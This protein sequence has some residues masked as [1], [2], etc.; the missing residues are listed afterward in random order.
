MNKALFLDR[1]GVVNIDKGYIYKKE[2]FVFIE[3]VFELCKHFQV[4]NFLIFIITNQSGVA[5][6][7]YTE[8]ELIKL[9]EWLKEEFKNNGITLSKIYYSTS[10]DDND[11]FRKP[12]PGMLLEAKKEFDIDLE[13]SILIG[14]K[15]SDAQCGINAGVGKIFLY[16]NSTYKG[17]AKI[18]NIK[19]LYEA[20]LID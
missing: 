5:R 7:Y 17:N 2:D 3:G 16:N 8:I 11:F 15:D 4:K 13:H 9:N 18:I 19:N 1:D 10:I 14:D 20:F 12:N 6:G